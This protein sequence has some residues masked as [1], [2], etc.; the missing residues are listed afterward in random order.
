MKSRLLRSTLA[1]ALLAV[2]TLGVPLLLVARHQVWASSHDNLRQEAVSVAAGIEDQLDLGRPIDLT[3]YAGAL[4]RR[5]I[6]VVTSSGGRITTGSDLTGRPIEASVTVTGNTI[7]VQTD[8]GPTVTRAREVTALVIGLALLAVATAVGLALRQARRLTQPLSELLDR[9]DALGRGDFSTVEVVSGIPE[10]DGI[11]RVLERSG[12]QLGTIIE[13]QRDF[14]SDAAHSLR[15]PLTGIGLRLEELSR[16]GDEAVR[17]EAEDALAQVERLDRVIGVLLARARGDAAEPGSVDVGVLVEHEAVGWTRAL[18]QRGRVLTVSV[19]AGMVVRARR[20]H[21]A[22]VLSCLLDNALQHGA[23]R[24][25][26]TCRRRAAYVEVAVVDEGAGV[27]THLA[28]QVFERRVS[29]SSGT[30]IGLAL[31]RSLAAAEAGALAL[32]GRSRFVLTLPLEPDR[33]L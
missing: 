8:R 24:V 11:S 21:L 29:G 25:N 27:P 20:D 9:A 16:I 1:I 19:D 2:V 13:L 30:G 33:G 12:Q 4:P 14:A 10:I 3:R 6:V 28:A 5:R 15:T 17:A 31:A 23:G 26:L 22:G 18:A 7:T 32:D